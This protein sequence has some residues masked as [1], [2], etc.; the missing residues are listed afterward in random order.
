MNQEL[1]DQSSCSFMTFDVPTV[2]TVIRRN[3]S[4]SHKNLFSFPFSRPS[5]SPVSHWAHKHQQSRVHSD[6]FLLSQDVRWSGAI[7][8]P[9]VGHCQSTKQG[10]SVCQPTVS[11]CLT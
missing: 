2:F 8:P 11:F 3:L 7:V 6:R 1:L 5:V 9:P 10:H 4:Q